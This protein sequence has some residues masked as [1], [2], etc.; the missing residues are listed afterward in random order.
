MIQADLTGRKTLVTGAAS[1]IGLATSE[2]F[3][4]SGATVA[5]NYLPGDPRGPEQVDRL[6]ADGLEVVAAPGNVAL[7][8]EA[9]AMVEAAISMLG[10][11]DYLFNNA[12]TPVTSKPIPPDELD[13]LDEEFWQTILTTNLIG[14]FRCA[15]AAAPA[16]KR[17]TGAI[18]NTA[19]SAGLGQQGSSSSYAASKSG[20]VSLTRSL[21]RGLGPEVR[22]NA[23]APGAVNSPWQ[24]DWPDEYKRAT[25]ENAVLKRRCEPEDIAE[26]VLFLCAGGAMITGQT[27]LIDGGLT[28]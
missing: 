27:I 20:L 8:G 21:A 12:G 10:G 18:V 9:E 11:L 16:L 17:A 4:R 2:L 19:S 24:K 1:G 28:L 22:V 23:V 3:A 5:L 13:K 26:V 15:R 6:R 14:P 25:I 7:P